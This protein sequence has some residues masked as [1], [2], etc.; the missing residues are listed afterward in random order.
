MHIRTWSY[1]SS[2][3]TVNVVCVII[4]TIYVTRMTFQRKTMLTKISTDN[5]DGLTA[6]ELD[7]KPNAVEKFFRCFSLIDNGRLI[8][9]HNL[10]RESISCIHGMR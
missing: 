1:V 3:F 8:V 2:I 4:G 6:I 7:L 9:S 5:H 10:G